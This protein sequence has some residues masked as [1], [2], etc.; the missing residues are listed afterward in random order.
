MEQ[1]DP[2]QAVGSTE[3]LGPRAQVQACRPEDRA[4]LATPEGAELLAKAVAALDAYRCIAPLCKPL[5][6]VNC[7][8]AVPADVYTVLMSAERD[9]DF[10]WTAEDQ[11]AVDADKRCA[12]TQENDEGS[13]TWATAC[14]RLFCVTEGTPAENGMRF[15]CFCGETLHECAFEPGADAGA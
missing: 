10:S 8:C 2:P 5:G 7:N 12:W 13:D 6:C 9:A 14:G 3:G 15:C 11:A 1:R 4:L